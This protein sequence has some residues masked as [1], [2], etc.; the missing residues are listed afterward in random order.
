MNF[1]FSGCCPQLIH[2]THA[3]LSLLRLNVLVISS[4][5]LF[6]A[7]GDDQETPPKTTSVDNEADETENVFVTALP[8]G[9][10]DQDH[11]DSNNNTAQPKQMES[12]EDFFADIGYYQF[13]NE[14]EQ[15]S[16]D[17]RSQ[18]VFSKLQSKVKECQQREKSVGELELNLKQARLETAEA[19]RRDAV[20]QK[21]NDELVDEIRAKEEYVNT[22][23][24]SMEEKRV[25]VERMEMENE[26]LKRKIDVGPGWTESQ[27]KEKAR[28]S[29]EIQS[30]RKEAD[31]LNHRSADLRSSLENL[32]A[33]V[34]EAIKQRQE[35]IRHLEAVEIKIDEAE[36]RNIVEEQKV[37]EAE[38]NLQL[39]EA[40]L[41]HLEDDLASV[42]KESEE[43]MA[44]VEH[45][46][47][48][49]EELQLALSG[50]AIDMEN[51]HQEEMRLIKE[52]S[53]TFFILFRSNHTFILSFPTN[54]FNP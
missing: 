15:N 14:L 30:N 48:E 25:L 13:L 9:N 28:L 29:E 38:K 3:T 8:K 26:E 6:A 51:M 36:E 35:A 21:R 1:E 11:Q 44:A 34:K 39:S 24:S 10:H 50:C 18:E 23:H 52:V 53:A 16:L 19:S 20:D 5:N 37:N 4:D 27:L 31:I 12:Q 22:I 45:L 17:A 47:Q 7:M 46:N 42:K 54:H 49:M 43:E 41:Q 2:I 33:Q 32:E 40:S